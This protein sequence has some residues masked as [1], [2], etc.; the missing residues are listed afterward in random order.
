MS[1]LGGGR[2]T[3]PGAPR[4]TTD[5]PPRPGVPRG[6]TERAGGQERRFPSPSRPRHGGAA[7]WASFRGRRLGGLE[8][9]LPHGY[10]GLVL[11]EG[12]NDA[13]GRRLQVTGTFRTVTA[14]EADAAPSPAEGLPLAL[15]WAPLA[16]AIHAP[17]SHDSDEEAEP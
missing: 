2:T 6:T 5:A 8:L 14:W 11:A 1:L 13:Q 15:V 9:P 10:R 3:L 4:G 16:Q 12:P 17:V 7:L